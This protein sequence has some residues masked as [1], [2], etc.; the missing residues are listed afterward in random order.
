MHG[1]IH[2]TVKLSNNFKEI[3]KK[4]ISLTSG[5]D[6]LGNKLSIINLNL[7]EPKQAIRKFI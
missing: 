6:P 3:N 5:N 7:Y 4:T 2:E 1:H